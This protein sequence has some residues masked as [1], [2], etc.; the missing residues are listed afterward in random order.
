MPSAKRDS[1]FRQFYCENVK[2]VLRFEK[3]KPVL[4]EDLE[5]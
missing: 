3:T 4:H 1:Y 2:L 5:N